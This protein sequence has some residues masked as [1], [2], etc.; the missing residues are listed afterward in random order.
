M[1]LLDLAKCLNDAISELEKYQ[2][3]EGST[4]VEAA[5]EQ[6]ANQQGAQ[7]AQ[8]GALQALL[9]PLMAQAFGNKKPSTL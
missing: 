8:G 9:G 5:L 6:A 3:A 4:A 7:G 2:T 1:G